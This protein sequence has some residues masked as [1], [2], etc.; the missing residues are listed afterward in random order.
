MQNLII[1]TDYI[2]PW[3]KLILEKLTLTK[4]VMKKL[5]NTAVQ[6]AFISSW[7]FLPSGIQHFHN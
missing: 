1:T 3:S 2:T 7:D 6:T 4:P 5:Y